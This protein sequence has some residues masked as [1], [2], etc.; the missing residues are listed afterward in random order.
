MKERRRFIRA[1]TRF[2]V[3][4]FLGGKSS[5]SQASGAR[6]ISQGGV[7]LMFNERI[8]KDTEIGLKFYLPEFRSPVSCRGRVIWQNEVTENNRKFY[9]TGIEFTEIE[10]ADKEKISKYI[11]VLLK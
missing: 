1:D 9:Q 6:N 7:C 4:Y 3:E 11:Y 8:D 10:E 5:S 2:N